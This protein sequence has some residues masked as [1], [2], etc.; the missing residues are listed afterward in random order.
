MALLP[1][2]MSVALCGDDVRC[3][4]AKRL[5]ASEIPAISISDVKRLAG[6][7]RQTTPW[8][9]WLSSLVCVDTQ[10]GCQCLSTSEQTG[11]I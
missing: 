3:R 4:F 10:K 11:V 2:D 5:M 8:H 1:E 9:L 6:A 7:T